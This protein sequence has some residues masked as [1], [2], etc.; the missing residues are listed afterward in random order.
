MALIGSEC[1]TM[2]DLRNS[3]LFF[4]FGQ[5][6]RSPSFGSFSTGSTRKILKIP[7]NLDGSRRKHG[8]TRQEEKG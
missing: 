1:A 7:G 2:L 5:K 8:R 6:E 3:I 4:P